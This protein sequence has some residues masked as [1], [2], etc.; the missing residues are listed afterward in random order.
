MEYDGSVMEGC[1]DGPYRL[2]KCEELQSMYLNSSGRFAT[3][4]GPK[5][6]IL[7][8]FSVL[9]FD[10]IEYLGHCIHNACL[11]APLNSAT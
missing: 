9:R 8:Y 4:F 6:K 10:C 11:I 5:G 2:A 1:I 3:W 7:W